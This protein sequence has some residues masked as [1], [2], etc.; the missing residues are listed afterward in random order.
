METSRSNPFISKIKSRT[1]LNKEG[2]SKSTFHVELSAHP[3]L[4]YSPGDSLAILPHYS[5]ERITSLLKLFNSN[6]SFQYKDETLPL[7]QLL[8]SKLNL[9]TFTKKFLR[10]LSSQDIDNQSVMQE[11]LT[12]SEKCKAFISEH[13][14]E[15][16]LSFFN[17]KNPDI[18]ELISSLAPILPRMYSIASSKLEHPN[19]IHLTIATFTYRKQDKVCSGLGSNFL[20]FCAKE[21]ETD[22]PY[23]IH[24]SPNFK[25]PLSHSTD[26]IM[27]GPGTGIAPYRAFLQER[28]AQNSTGKHWL[29]FGDRN[30]STDFYYEDFFDQFKSTH[31]LDIDLAFSRDQKQKIYVQNKMDKQRKKLWDWLKNGAH[32]YICGDAKQMARDVQNTIQSIAQSEGKLS[33]AEAKEFMRSLRKEG[34]LNLDV[35]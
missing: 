23:Y 24:K 16:A 27:V 21:E 22:I 2:S 18:Q 3:D 6:D 26:I 20:C 31:H 13:I 28:R 9:D 17:P 35:Y 7:E 30:R 15:S 14:L 4:L 1:L 11:L 10:A 12:D 8:K 5:K 25:L 34:R 33:E 29:F 19:E 32:L